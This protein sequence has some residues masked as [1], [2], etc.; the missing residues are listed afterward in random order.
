MYGETAS[1]FENSGN[2]SS[3]D[4]SDTPGDNAANNNAAN[5][6]AAG[7]NAAGNN[8]AGNNAA[9]N[10]GSTYDYSD[11]AQLPSGTGS[12]SA[13][14]PFKRFLIA[15]AGPAVNLVFA[16]FTLWLLFIIGIPGDAFG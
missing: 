6:N 3:D 8:A 12:F 4:N 1:Q 14:P 16:V 2:T 9:S 15:F 13:L 10:S 11:I 5:N 7:N